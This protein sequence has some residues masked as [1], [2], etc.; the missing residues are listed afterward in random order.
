MSSDLHV[1]LVDLGATR[2]TRVLRVDAQTPP[3]LRREALQLAGRELR[4]GELVAFPTETVY[5]LGADATNTEAVE[6]IF[7][8]KGRPGDNPLIV[9]IDRVERLRQVVVHIPPAALELAAAF[10]PGPL[11]MVLPKRPEISLAATAGLETVGVRLPDHP[12]A[13]ELI[14]AADRPI[15]A[16]SANL[17]GRPSPTRAEHVLEDLAG[18]VSLI[19]DGGPCR[20]GVESTVVDMTVD[21]PVLLRPGGVTLEALQKV[22]GRVE[23]DRGVWER[24]EA[25]RVRSPGM[26]YRH[27]APKAPAWLFEGEAGAVADCLARHAGDYLRQGNRIGLVVSEETA[28]TI[29]EALPQLE[30][31]LA[32][33][34]AYLGVAGRRDRPEEYAHALFDL[35]RRIDAAGVD[36]VLMEGVPAAGIGLAV[37]NRLRRAAGY[38]IVRCE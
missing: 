2:V 3:R 19:L 33:G 27:Y 12:V 15:A 38:Q 28:R 16:P 29:R 23:V 32:A 4:R 21:P 31:A 35:L 1:D 26:K 8:A 14:A 30:A 7:R 6:R 34:T 18:R 9:H 11:T 20:I 5:G 24:V 37:A 10:W 17:S 13:R 36:V 22:L 25:G